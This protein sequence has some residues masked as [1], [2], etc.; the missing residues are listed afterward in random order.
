MKTFEALR[1]LP[2]PE[3]FA[4]GIFTG[5]ILAFGYIVYLQ[6][7]ETTL[8]QGQIHAVTLIWLSTMAAY[9]YSQLSI[10]N[11]A[12]RFLYS[13][14]MTFWFFEMH[15]IFWFLGTLWIGVRVGLPTKYPSLKW[16]YTATWQYFIYLLV[17]MFLLRKYLNPN[18]RFWA[19]YIFQVSASAL[20]IAFQ[21]LMIDLPFPFFF[22][23]IIYDSFPYFFIIR[24]KEKEA[25]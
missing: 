11:E 24:K 5:L 15:D 19:F 13:A 12:Q 8:S 18:R 4:Y 20:A 10:I 3:N 9:F 21:Y 6:G 2:I 7:L 17:S 1:D 25:A 22:L 23:Q 14:I 16:Y